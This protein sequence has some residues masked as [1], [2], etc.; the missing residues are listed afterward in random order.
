ML[1]ILF[2]FLV[3]SIS[4]LGTLSFAEKQEGMSG[5]YENKVQ[6]TD[7]IFK[8]DFEIS[9]IAV[10]ESY[11]QN[12]MSVQNIP[13]LSIL[14]FREGTVLYENYLGKSQIEQNISLANDHLFLLASVSKLI[15]A[16]ALLQLYDDGAFLLDDKIN[17]YLSFNVNVPNYTADIT[18]RMLLTHTS[19]IADGSVLDSHYY[20]GIDSPIQLGYFL[21]NYLVPGGVYYNATEN[22]NDF[23][24]GSDFAYSNEGNALIGLLVEQISGVNFNTYCK[25]NIFTPLGMSNSFWRLDEISQ[26]IVQPYDYTNGQFIAIDHYTFTDYPNG[27]LRSTATDLFKFLSAFVQNGV[28]NNYQLLNPSTISAMRTPQ[29]P[30]LEATMGLHLFLMDAPN[31]LWGHDGG[32]QGVATILAFNPVTKVGAILLSNQG[33]VNLDEM[34]IK[35]YQLGIEL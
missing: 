27:G 34:L 13:A 35:S 4:G 17:D 31:E 1:K 28:S 2:A 7:V 21:E 5:T 29:I 8:N 6:N 3:I 32:E 16:T 11:I 22:F 20:Y 26:T 25:T 18:F 15:T 12:Q 14:I 24:P 23:S 33:D 10:F 30:L 9:N 19:A